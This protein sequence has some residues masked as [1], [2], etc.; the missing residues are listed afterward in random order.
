MKYILI[1]TFLFSF[2]LSSKATSQIQDILLMNNDTFFLYNSP[3]AQ[4]SYLLERDANF[5]NNRILTTTNKR[6][7]VAFW[8]L[9]DNEIFLTKI[10]NEHYEA[11]LNVIFKT[12]TTKEKIKAIWINERLIARS[13]YPISG[14]RKGLTNVYEEEYILEIENGKLVGS[15]YL[16]NH[17]AK[18]PNDITAIL[19]KYLVRK[20][21]RK[22][23]KQILKNQI[24]YDFHTI[25][26]FDENKEIKSIEFDE[27]ENDTVHV[28]NLIEKFDDWR[29]VY[30][31]GSL[32][33]E[34]AVRIQ[35]N[36]NHFKRNKKGRI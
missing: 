12:E 14:Y 27:T 32:M 18:H 10:S 22:V 36:S 9:I 4:K 8:E 15:K 28:K 25:V 1:I 13:R 2:I 31:E 6:G 17:H 26:T 23:K 11:N 30:K 24:E 34:Y 33:K 16:S 35:I 21:P 20:L 3:F 7:Y 29:F 19:N 5:I